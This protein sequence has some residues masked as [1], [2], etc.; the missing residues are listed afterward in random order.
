MSQ[1]RNLGTNNFAHNNFAQKN[2]WMI[3]GGLGLK[4]SYECASLF[5]LWIPMRKKR[6]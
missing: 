2:S 1:I 6:V 4:I 3:I 5:S